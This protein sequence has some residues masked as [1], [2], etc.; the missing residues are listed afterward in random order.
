MNNYT[1]TTT[2]ERQK[3]YK[4]TSTCSIPFSPHKKKKRCGQTNCVRV[5]EREKNIHLLVVQQEKEKNQLG[6]TYIYI[7]VIFLSCLLL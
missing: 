6:R 3:E 1:T 4:E 5:T 2:R 7:P